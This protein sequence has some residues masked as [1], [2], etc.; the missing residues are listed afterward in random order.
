MENK[1]LLSEGTHN[2][3]ESSSSVVAIYFPSTVEESV[4]S[5]PLQTKGTPNGPPSLLLAS[6]PTGETARGR[7][8][9]PFIKRG[10]LEFAKADVAPFTFLPEQVGVVWCLEGRTLRTHICRDHA[11]LPHT[12]PQLGDRRWKINC[13]FQKRPTTEINLLLPL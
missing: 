3:N 9:G 6:L 2:P 10:T 8:G 11:C 5:T 12:T 1:L 4:S 7:E 13:Y